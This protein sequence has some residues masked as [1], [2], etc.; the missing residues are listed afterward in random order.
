MTSLPHLDTVFDRLRRG[1]HYTPD[2]GEVFRALWRRFDDYRAAFEALGLDLR[3]HPENVVFLAAGPSDEPGKQAREMGLFVLVMVEWMSDERGAV[4]PDFFETWWRT[5]DLPHL[6]ADR[7][8]E[9]MGQ[10]GVTS[11]GDLDRVVRTLAGYGFAEARADGAF[12]FRTAAH[13]FLDL[14]M[15]AMEQTP[16]SSDAETP[17]P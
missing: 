12:R 5:D 3:K 4:L 2:D 16:A 11:P 6:G 17:A 9:Y 13:R 10:V 8:R 14:C 15:E 7:Y 1:Y